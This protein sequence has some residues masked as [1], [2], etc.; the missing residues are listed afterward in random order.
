MPLRCALVDFLHV[1]HP[2]ERANSPS[3]FATRQWDTAQPA[4]NRAFLQAETE[5]ISE[6]AR[7]RL[8]PW[9]RA[10]AAYSKFLHDIRGSDVLGLA[11]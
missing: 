6:K 8:F 2:K 4:K 10:P 5:L 3:D 9:I 11:S 7:R 1:C